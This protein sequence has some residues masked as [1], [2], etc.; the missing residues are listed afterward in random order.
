M[1]FSYNKSNYKGNAPNNVLE[2]IHYL[3]EKIKCFENNV[4]AIFGIKRYNLNT[5]YIWFKGG[6]FV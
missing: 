1:C 2:N 5:L 6:I 3:S 4:F